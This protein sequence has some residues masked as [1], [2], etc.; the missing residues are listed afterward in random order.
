MLNKVANEKQKHA[1]GQHEISGRMIE[2]E[3]ARDAADT[4]E[5]EVHDR[6]EFYWRCFSR[7]AG[8]VKRFQGRGCRACGAL[9]RRSG[10]DLRR[11]ANPDLKWARSQAWVA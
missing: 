8:S 6:S 2:V 11:A 5:E 10:N 3:A 4:A 1:I 9:G 7:Q